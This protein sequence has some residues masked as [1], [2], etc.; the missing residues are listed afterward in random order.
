[1]LKDSISFAPPM[2]AALL[3]GRKIASRRLIDP[4]P[5]ENVTSA[6][7]MSRNGVQTDEWTWLS[8]DPA[9][10]DS[11]SCEG[12]FSTGYVPGARLWVRER[13]WLDIE[14]VEG[15]GCR[16]AFFEGG[17]V[18]FEDGRTGQAPGHP[19]TYTA[20]MFGYNGGLVEVAA[21]DLPRWA[22]RLTV[23]IDAV[24]VALLH[25]ITEDE[26]EAEGFEAGLLDDG[27]GPRDF[28]DGVTISSPG[29]WASAAGKF[30]MFWQE[31]YP[32]WDGFTDPFVA[33]L[34]F[35]LERGSIDRMLV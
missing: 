12:D 4:Q 19:D 33:I 31:L 8:G 27:F 2:I 16:R 13:A 22:S 3:A 15:V 5:G 30:L 17:A 11:W 10:I 21:A 9:D 29:T 25:A 1:M 23:T 28:G 32:E 35:E 18:Q 14:P 6:G 34:Q 24:T 7:V 26:A 20:E